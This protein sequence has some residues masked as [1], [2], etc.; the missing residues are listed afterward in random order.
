MVNGFFMFIIIIIIIIIV[1][2]LIE[3]PYGWRVGIAISRC[4]I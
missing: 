2:F 1:A 4:V 3:T